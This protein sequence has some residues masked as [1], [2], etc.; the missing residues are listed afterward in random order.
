MTVLVTLIG[1]AF[2]L[3]ALREIFQQL[4]NPSGGGSLS[5]KLMRIVWGAFRRIASR[6]PALLSLA[7]PFVFLSILASW[8]T[9]LAVGWALI[10][11][12][13]LSEGFLYQTGLDPSRN[14]GFLAALYVSLTTLTT[15]GYGDIVP[16]AWWLRV[17]QPL[18]ALTGFAV[19]TVSVTWLLSIY[20]VLSRRRAFARDV[21]LIRE[22]EPETGNVVENISP[23]AA[24]EMLGTLTSRLATVRGDLDRFPISYYFYEA[25]DRSALSGAIPYL[26]WLAE[27]AGDEDHAAGVRF[28]AATLRG[29]IRDLSS[30]LGAGFLDLPSAPVDKVLDAYARDHFRTPRR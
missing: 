22:S 21:H 25:D 5:R 30:T 15:L 2:I 8:V 10:L 18:Q 20:P 27:R 3:V 7:G 14:D 29:A 24:A 23:D 4:F 26:A 19:L 13:H 16:V 28:R 1:A 9:L 12:L 11:W 17:L 6:R